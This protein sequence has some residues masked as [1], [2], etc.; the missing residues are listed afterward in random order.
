MFDLTGAF[1]SAIDTVI[2]RPA[3]AFLVWIYQLIVGWLLLV[4]KLAVGVVSSRVFWI[5]LA[6]IVIVKVIRR[7]IRARRMKRLAQPDTSGRGHQMLSSM[8]GKLATTS[9]GGSEILDV[10]GST[11][12][13]NL[14][15]K[16][17]AIIA[18]SLSIIP[19]AGHLYVGQRSKAAV[20]FA[21]APLTLWFAW[22][23]A[24]ILARR[25]N[26]RGNLGQW[27]CFWHGSNWKIVETKDVATS[28]IFF[29]DEDRRIDN[30]GSTTS[31]ERTFAFK[32][33]W[34]SSV[35]FEQ[36][37]IQ[38]TTAS[39]EQSAFSGTLMSVRVRGAGSKAS[40]TVEETLRQR[41]THTKREE[42]TQAETIRVV[43]PA[44]TA[45]TL[46]LR[47]KRMVSKGTLVLEDQWKNRITAPFEVVTGVTFDQVRDDRPELP[48]I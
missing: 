15:V 2:V 39:E 27:E 43:I 18:K 45:T 10:S 32:R 34:S 25:Y 37:R 1:K 12:T 17:K 7:L 41:F 19:G 35:T 47:W 30:T 5:V 11:S 36:E 24:D 44:Y 13:A 29:S 22:H 46:K 40:R 26:E 20:M 21:F 3:K 38:K 16:K 33:K 6:V 31:I 48:R 4:Y 42:N 8:D 9:L 23:D 14:V 28:E